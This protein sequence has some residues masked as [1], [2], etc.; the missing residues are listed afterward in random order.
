MKIR[1]YESIRAG[2]APS[3]LHIQCWGKGRLVPRIDGAEGTR[4]AS[5]SRQIRYDW[6]ILSVM[7]EGVS[8][9]V[10]W[11]QLVSARGNSVEVFTI[12]LLFP[13]ET[14]AAG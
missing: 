11:V 3:G 14:N 2:V 10:H 1:N 5:F 4:W 8:C 9:T 7:R 12:I 13:Y 6:T